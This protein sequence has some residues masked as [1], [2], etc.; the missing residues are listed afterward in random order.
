[1]RKSGH[2]LERSFRGNLS[3]L[4]CDR[5][6]RF[7][8]NKDFRKWNKPCRPQLIP[9]QILQ[10][11]ERTKASIIR[12]RMKTLVER[13]KMELDEAPIKRI[14]VLGTFEVQPKEE[15]EEDVK[16]ANED[17]PILP[18]ECRKTER[19]EGAPANQEAKKARSKTEQGIDAAANGG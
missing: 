3:G 8:Q 7:H 9:R 10:H 11:H 15:D 1:M 4:R 18:K 14:R 16:A 17:K 12:E 5:C 13:A 2:T 6:Q 19:T